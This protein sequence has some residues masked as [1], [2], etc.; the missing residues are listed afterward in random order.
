MSRRALTLLVS[1]FLVL[2]L[3]IGGALVDVP[4]VVLSPGP[5][6]N[7]LGQIDKQP[8]IK[9]TGRETYPTSGSLRLVTVAYQGGPTSQIDLLTALRGWIDPTVAV[10]PQETIFAPDRSQK[11]VEEENTVEMTNSQDDATAAALNELKIPYRTV[12]SVVS[13][14]K[15]KPAAGKIEKG[16]EITS[17]DGEPVTKTEEVGEAVRARRAGEEVTFGITRG[18][19]DLKITVP[20]VAAD[21][22]PVVGVSMRAT[23]KFP[24]EVDINVGEVGGPSAGLMFSLGIVDKLTEGP[25]TGGKQIAGTGTIKPDGTVGPIGGIPQKLVGARDA[26]ATIFLTPA[27][28][29]A[30]AMKAVPD[31]LRLVKAETLNSARLAIEAL[32]SGKGKVPSCSG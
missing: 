21:G 9:I 18:D 31:G 23:Y 30:E 15:D 32:V 29:C 27:G 10:V 4:Y 8:V 2:A 20:T 7:T 5:T 6:E 19:E 14:A 12:I 17:V 1:G 3:G 24:F 26:G 16:D 28:N 13:V 11:E 22:E 25:M